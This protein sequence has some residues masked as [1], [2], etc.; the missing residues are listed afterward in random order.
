MGL[1]GCGL[2]VRQD[3]RDGSDA[4]ATVE[5]ISAQAKFKQAVTDEIEGDPAATD[6]FGKLTD[7]RAT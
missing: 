5:P 1:A 4:G 2:S 6:I 3:V 7:R